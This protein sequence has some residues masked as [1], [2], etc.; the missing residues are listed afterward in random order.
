MDRRTPDGYRAMNQ[1]DERMNMTTPSQHGTGPR[2]TIA[3][4]TLNRLKYL[5]LALESAL[6]QTYTNIEVIVSNNASTDETA[7]YLG[8][9][10]DPRL[11]V[12]TQT[13]LLPMTQ[14]WNTC[15][16]DVTGEFFLLLSDDDVLEPSAIEE[17]VAA[18]TASGEGK[19]GA[20]IVYCGG[21]IIDAAGVAQKTFAYSPVRESARDLLLAFF[22]GQ[23]DLW[24]CAILFR[25]SDIKP[26]F[27][28]EYS[29]APDSVI[30]INAVFNRNGAVFVPHELVQYRVHNNA[31]ASLSMEIWQREL[32]QLGQLA[33]SR[34]DALA[35]P[36]ATFAEKLTT[37]IRKLIIRSIP[38][39]INGSLH[40]HKL[41]ALR[42]YKECLPLMANPYGIRFLAMGLTFL[43]LPKDAKPWLRSILKGKPA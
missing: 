37:T 7:S 41:K 13:T 18:Y 6:T 4:P 39:R 3:I 19:D 28:L 22:S 9:C 10:T 17:M 26:G 27:S 33:I 35:N 43:F 25:T 36:N 20:G 21:R 8:A 2:V 14:N 30:W 16:A 34:S 42:Q 23:R 24:L 40:G 31:T 12:L 11:R 5:R 15:V 1:E 38:L 29:W 32:K